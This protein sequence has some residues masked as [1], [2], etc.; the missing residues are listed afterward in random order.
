MQRTPRLHLAPGLLLTT[1]LALAQTAMC[2]VNGTS[3]SAPVPATLLGTLDQLWTFLE[4]VERTVALSVSAEVGARLE[5]IQARL[6]GHVDA[7]TLRLDGQDRQT[8]QLVRE[9]GNLSSRV[10]DASR[11]SEVR[12]DA[13]G[14]ELPRDCS[15]LP[16]GTASGIRLLRPGLDRSLPPVPAF[17]DMD[18]DGGGWTVIQR[19]AD[20]Q[21]RQDFY[22]GWQAYRRGFGELDAEFWWGLD[23]MWTATSARDRRYELRVD[24]WDFDGNTRHA[25]YGNFRVASESEG[26]RLT[27]VNF[28]GDAGDGLNFQNGMRFTTKDTDNDIHTTNNCAHSH[29]G[30]WWYRNCHES[31]LNGRYLGRTPAK[32]AY[33]VSW[34]PW[35]GYGYSLKT[36]T[37]K[38]RPTYKL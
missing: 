32:D 27:A 6:A 15:D 25:R 37:M 38:I 1:L 35:R 13:A 12:S 5:G 20:I 19:R 21:P 30:A 10:E 34:Y 24:L 8:S 4:R 7:L 9:I 17:C 31:N 18:A 14:R 28:T 33:G 29:K 16:A 26:Y 23:N 2:S 36:V 22:L 3:A 11:R